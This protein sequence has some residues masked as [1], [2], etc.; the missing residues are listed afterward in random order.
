MKYILQ[1][2]TAVDMLKLLKKSITSKIIC[3]DK[4]SYR[5]CDKEYK[6]SCIVQC[7]ATK[8]KTIYS[9]LTKQDDK[10]LNV[11]MNQN[12]NRFLY[13]K[14]AQTHELNSRKFPTQR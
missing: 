3:D 4:I 9:F 2:K 7:E 10:L 14:V 8:N 1:L 11:N 12:L 5:L 6:I 13:N